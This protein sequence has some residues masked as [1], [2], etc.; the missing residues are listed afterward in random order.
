MNRV[1]RHLDAVSR[2][3]VELAFGI[4][5][6]IEGTVDAYFGPPLIRDAV[7]AGPIPPPDI[8]LAQ[9]NELLDRV[10]AVDLAPSRVDYLTAQLRALVTT[11]RTLAGE[12][13]G[14]HEEVRF[15]FDIEPAK[16]P[17]TV[18]QEAIR[19]GVSPKP[20]PSLRHVQ[21]S[22]RASVPPEKPGGY[23]RHHPF[24]RQAL[25]QRDAVLST[26]DGSGTSAGLL[27]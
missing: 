11:C 7:Q 17:D 4:E 2:A 23:Q 24:V 20:D 26:H 9:A 12:E 5:R 1:A 13:I 14:Y 16:V 8:L 25:K 3:F 6:H 22:M 27:T 19:A 21:P 18:Y 10:T 15:L